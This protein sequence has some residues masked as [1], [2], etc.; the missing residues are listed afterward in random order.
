[1]AH[2]FFPFLLLLGPVSHL[3]KVDTGLDTY[4]LFMRLQLETY[5]S[6]W[7]FDAEAVYRGG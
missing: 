4:I 6:F 3:Y 7:E 1:M 2:D 5:L